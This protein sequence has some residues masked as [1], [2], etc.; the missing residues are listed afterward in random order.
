MQIL[1][2]MS[3]LTLNVIVLCRLGQSLTVNSCQLDQK[4]SQ[5]MD[6]SA[7]TVRQMIYV[8]TSYACF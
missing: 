5:H 3:N 8:L 6:V 7:V 2:V 4:H 1:Y